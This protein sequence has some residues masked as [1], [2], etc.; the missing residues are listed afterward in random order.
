MAEIN[1]SGNEARSG[2][3]WDRIARNI[4]KVLLQ[5]RGSTEDFTE[6]VVEG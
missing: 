5:E 3:V 4:G 1:P 6:S 2:Q